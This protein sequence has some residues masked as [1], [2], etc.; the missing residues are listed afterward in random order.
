MGKI[1]EKASGEERRRVYVQCRPIFSG[2]N[3]RERRGKKIIALVEG[4]NSLHPL[5]REIGKD[6][7][8]QILQGLLDKGI[9]GSEHRA[10]VEF[11]DLFPP[12]PHRDAQR[13]ASELSAARSTAEVLSEI[14]SHSD[15][16]RGFAA[17]SEAGNKSVMDTSVEPEPRARSES[18]EKVEEDRFS[19]RCPSLYPAYLPYQTQ[20]LIVNKAQQVLEECCF[21]FATVSM[22]G[23]LQEKNWEC[24]AAAEL[25]EWT[26][27]FLKGKSRWPGLPKELGEEG[28]ELLL[29]VANIRHTAV[30]RLPTTAKG[31]CRLLESAVK[32]AQVLRDDVRAN[33]L[34][35][36]R[37]ELS[38]KIK[39]MELNKNILEDTL[40]SELQ[41]I[42]KQ[43]KGLDEK[44]ARLIQA[45]L[46]DD[47]DNKALIGQL[48]EESVRKTFNK[49]GGDDQGESEDDKEDN[50]TEDGRKE[51]G[52]EEVAAIGRK[53]DADAEE[54]G[55]KEGGRVESGK[56]GDVYGA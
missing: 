19:I 4:S 24:P 35:E 17:G 54:G 43:R 10:K 25:T 37:T 32:F 6:R 7:V 8:L 47:M 36:L 50:G 2:E 1:N 3:A 42:Q 12:S 18:Q 52:E 53:P 48:L 46:K 34:N 15:K 11:P 28:R 41:A 45:M 51:E 16:G 20:H 49:N 56:V 38:S 31:V 39:A 55:C 14:S 30:H 29:E 13:H 5:L 9:F 23:L 22:S 44:E 27:M 21:D 33:Q 40:A 26:S